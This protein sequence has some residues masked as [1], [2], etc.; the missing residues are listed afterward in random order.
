MTLNGVITVTFRYF[1][2]D[3]FLVK[4]CS[5]R[6]QNNAAAFSL[7]SFVNIN[8]FKI[9]LRFNCEKLSDIINNFAAVNMSNFCLVSGP[10]SSD[11]Y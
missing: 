1:T 11:I 6:L 10:N 3:K 7:V 9:Q 8:A 4:T 2:F 5:H